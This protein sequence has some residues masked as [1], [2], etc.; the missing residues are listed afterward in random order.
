MVGSPNLETTDFS[1]T[2]NAVAGFRADAEYFAHLLNAHYVGI[3]LQHELI[4]ITLGN[5]CSFDD[6]VITVSY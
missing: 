1:F 2:Q 5:C 4:S 6:G 3:V